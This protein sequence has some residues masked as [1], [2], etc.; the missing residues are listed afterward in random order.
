[1]AS[2]SRALPSGRLGGPRP[3][4]T[5]SGMTQKPKQPLHAALLHRALLQTRIYLSRES[6]SHVGPFSHS[7]SRPR[8]PR[9]IRL[10]QPG[11]SAFAPSHFRFVT[12]GPSLPGPHFRP[13]ACLLSQVRCVRLPGPR[14][15]ET[16]GV[17]PSGGASGGT[18]VN[19]FI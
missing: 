2:H 4:F 5:V 10:L 6:S 13:R 1:M 11:P 8:L 19:V 17:K 12:S 15:R 7:H 16:R 18:K 9:P 3:S 14:V